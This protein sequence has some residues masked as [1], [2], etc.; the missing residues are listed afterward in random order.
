MALMF[1]SNFGNRGCKVSERES[2]P[3][4]VFADPNGGVGTQQDLIKHLYNRM[5][6]QFESS[7]LLSYSRP[8]ATQ[9]MLI[10]SPHNVIFALRLLPH[11]Q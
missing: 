7:F 6:M 9:F 4:I 10:L 1:V 11:E 5:V 3:H 2:D 8:Y